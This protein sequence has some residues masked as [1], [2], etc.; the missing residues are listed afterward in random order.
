V[1]GRRETTRLTQV[2]DVAGQ[3]DGVVLVAPDGGGGTVAGVTADRQEREH[4][5]QGDHRLADLS[6]AR[7]H[8]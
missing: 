7:P 3:E 8:D 4:Q 6:L 1:A 2:L 5:P